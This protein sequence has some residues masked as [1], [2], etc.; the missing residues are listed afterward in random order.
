VAVV[1]LV[2]KTAQEFPVVVERSVAGPNC[3]LLDA[4]IATCPSTGVP[5]GTA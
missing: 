5:D 2:L 3:W 4:A 1:F